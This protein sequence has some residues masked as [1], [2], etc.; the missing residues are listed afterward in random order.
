M[1]FIPNPWSRAKSTGVRPGRNGGDLRV[2]VTLTPRRIT[3]RPVGSTKWRPATDKEEGRC[4]GVAMGALFQGAGC[5]RVRSAELVSRPKVETTSNTSTARRCV[6]L[7]GRKLRLAHH[8]L[9]GSIRRHPTLIPTKVGRYHPSRSGRWHA[10]I[11]NGIISPVSPPSRPSCHR[12]RKRDAK[13]RAAT[14]ATSVL[15]KENK[16][17]RRLLHGGKK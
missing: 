8:G 5:R 7:V 16:R 15:S 3:T 17:E 11:Q 12:A 4:A 6:S 14:G 10:C 13:F 2:P 1:T 9:V